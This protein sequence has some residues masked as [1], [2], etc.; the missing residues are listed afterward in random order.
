MGQG[1]SPKVF[2][3]VP[4]RGIADRQQIFEAIYPHLVASYPFSEVLVADSGHKTFNR[5]ATR[6][7]L[8]DWAIS[9]SAD[10]LVINDADSMVSGDQLSTSINE[11][12]R[13]GKLH[14]PHSE[15]HCYQSRFLL[16][17]APKVG[18]GT[19]H[20]TYGRSCGGVLVGTPQMYLLA[21]GQDERITGWGYEDE[22]FIVS[23]RTFVGDYVHHPGKLITY[24]HTRE[25]RVERDDLANSILRDSYN[26]NIF[27]KEAIS[28]I[29][30]GSNRFRPI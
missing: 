29:Q 8:I 13:D 17:R 3:G 21:G 20:H 14:I 12:L 25:A 27:N 15:V 16:N 22:I 19:P 7:I 4:F 28:A 5:A 11:S 6:N 9:G 30:R 23:V 2:L 18:R 24:S 1:Y 26:Q 10:V